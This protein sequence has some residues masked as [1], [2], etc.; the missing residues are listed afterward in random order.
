[1]GTSDGIA[2]AKSLRLCLRWICAVIVPSSSIIA[3]SGCSQE[4]K[5]PSPDV[6]VLMNQGNSH[7]EKKEYDQAIALFS[8]AISVE[9]SNYRGYFWRSRVFSALGDHEKEI[10]DLSEVIRLNPDAESYDSRGL[11]YLVVN[12]YGKAIADANE[13][14]R[15]KPDYYHAYRTRA[16]AHFLQNNYRSAITDY[17]SF[18]VFRPIDAT[19]YAQRGKCYELIGDSAKAAADYTMALKFGYTSE[20][21]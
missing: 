4:N 21:K 6:F 9:P 14:L 1:M 2:K 10:A 12:D 11:S 5:N 3:A 13:A 17:S 20:G 15:L 7:Y 18:I 8:E 19:A 16:M